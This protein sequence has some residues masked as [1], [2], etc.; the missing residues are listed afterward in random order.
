[1]S[2][3]KDKSANQDVER[4][5]AEITGFLKERGILDDNETVSNTNKKGRGNNDTID[6]F[7]HAY[8]MGRI[9]MDYN[10]AIAIKAG[11]DHEKIVVNDP[12]ER[13]MDLHNN[14]MGAAY[15]W[16]LRNKGI[17]SPRELFLRIEQGME[18]GKFILYPQQEKPRNGKLRASAEDNFSDIALAGN[19]DQPFSKQFASLLQGVKEL[20]GKPALNGLSADNSDLAAAL[21]KAGFDS[22]F[23]A[24]QVASAVPGNQAGEVFAAQG[25]VG[26]AT[27]LIAK[28]NVADVQPGSAGSVMSDLSTKISTL[29]EPQAIN[30]PSRSQSL[31]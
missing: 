22:R 3:E 31:S 27:G 5:K 1:M 18:D 4:Y 14:A 28:V 2:Y 15:G 19:I 7:R 25:T 9:A 24:K 13:R 30:P 6:A 21:V 23:D 29:Q 20:D 17:T 16:E 12:A 10:Y 11:R 26:S 8:V